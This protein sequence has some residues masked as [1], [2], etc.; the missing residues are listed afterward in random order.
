MKKISKLMFI[1]LI[2]VLTIPAL[3]NGQEQQRGG[4][5]LSI[6]PTRF[7]YTIERG[8]AELASIQVKNITQKDVLAKAYINDFE[9]D[10]NTG[11]PKLI[12][13]SEEQSS[14]SI[15]DFVVGLQDFDIK[16]GETEVVDLPIQVPANA[17]PGAYYGAIRFTGVPKDEEFTED[18]QLALN[19]SVASIVLIEVPGNIEEKIEVV[20]VSA[21]LKNSSDESKPGSLFT[22]KPN[23]VGIEINNLGNG[24]SKP[25]GRVEVGGPWGS[26]EVYSYELND[27]SPRGNILPKST[28]LFLDDLE[29]VST[30]GR[31]TITANIS[32]GRGGEILEVKSS[33]WYIPTWLVIVLVLVVIA[34]IVLIYYLYRKYSSKGTKS[35]RRK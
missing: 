8:E 2:A 27:S 24:F 30:P 15:K 23:Q 35:K 11:N 14:S 17:A 10:G 1:A 25:F 29:G 5:G 12:I 32:H 19:A 31:Y 33:F 22:K 6:S 26:G 18:D 7:E 28:R 4:S 16:A 20:D 3:V 9:P 34:L 13:D 21:Y